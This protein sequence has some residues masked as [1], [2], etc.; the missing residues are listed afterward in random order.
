MSQVEI[1]KQSEHPEM[2]FLFLLISKEYELC[3]GHQLGNAV[4][5]N[6]LST[7]SHNH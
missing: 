6:S 4:K 3:P 2:Y 5:E 1:R 7:I